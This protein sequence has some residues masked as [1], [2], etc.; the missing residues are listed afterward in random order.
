MKSLMTGNYAASYAAKYAEVKVIAAYPITP[1]TQIVEK[2]SEMCA[3]GELKAKYIN[4]ESEH[5]VMAACIGA[6]STGVRAFTATSAQGLAYMHELLQWASRARLPI[7]MVNVNRAMA[8]GWNIWA[9]QNDSLS[10]RD[11]GWMQIYCKDNQ[12]VFDS[13][14]MAYG[15]GER[16]ML[17]TMVNLDA[18]FLSHTYE[19]LDLPDPEQVKKYL[20]DY[21]PELKMDTDKPHTFGTLVNSE[22]YTEFQHKIQMSME[23]AKKVITEECSK[24]K[25]IFGR[26]YG[27]IE[28][29]KLDDSED[30]LIASATMFETATL[31]ADRLREAGKKVGALRIRYFRPFPEEV[32]TAAL[33]GKNRA[34]VF[35]RDISFGAQGIFCQELRAVL[36]PKPEMPEIYGAILGLGGRDVKPEK[37]VSLYNDMDKG[38]LK[39]DK[40]VWGDLKL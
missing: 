37:L 24:Y 11:T 6:A 14:I 31:A 25:D 21:K 2:L 13:V 18:F 29:Y 22:F 34:L 30:V 17:P 27:Q 8:P 39:N 7:V 26:Q 28:E 10:Q 40:P 33:K 38:L 23:E 19:P 3:K 1:Q 16:V 12:E 32:L 36:Q 5:S 35:D 20:P 15:I 4:V 9:D